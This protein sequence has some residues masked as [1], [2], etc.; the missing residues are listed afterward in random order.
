MQP[1]EPV[2]RNIYTMSQREKARLKIGSLPV[3]LDDALN[4]MEKDRLVRKTL[5]DHIYQHYLTAKREVWEQYIQQV[6]PW[7]QKRYLTMY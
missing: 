2:N 5:G 1:P 6:H 4:Q 7:E 3:S